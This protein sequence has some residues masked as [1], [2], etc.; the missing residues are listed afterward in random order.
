MGAFPL[1]IAG[2]YLPWA[3]LYADSMGTLWWTVRL[4]E[5]DH[6]RPY[7]VTTERLR[8]FARESGLP[9]VLRSIDREVARARPAEDR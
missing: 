4:W 9:S 5:T 3:H 2:P 1:P 6:A 8:T 7:V